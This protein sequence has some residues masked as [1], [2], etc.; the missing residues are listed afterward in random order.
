MNS[1]VITGWDLR[2]CASCGGLMINFTDSTRPYA[3]VYYDLTNTAQSLG[4]SDTV[5]VFPIYMRV[6]WTHPANAYG[7]I[8]TITGF[9][10]E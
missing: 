6:N 1:A 9:Q 4:L 7:N 5:S 3:G 8:I 2:M 10:R